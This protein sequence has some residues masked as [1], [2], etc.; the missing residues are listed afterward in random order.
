MYYWRLPLACN[1]IETTDG[2]TTEEKSNTRRKGG[3]GC[4]TII[5]FN[6]SK[7][8]GG[9]DSTGSDQRPPYVG[10]GHEMGHARAIDE[11]IQS[12]SN[13]EIALGI[14]K[15]EQQSMSV[16]NAIRLEHHLPLRPTY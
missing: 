16:E 3:L 5:R 7:T 8:S 13:I 12:Y 1:H 9:I 11:G 4:D 15:S 10:L 6:P 2:N 14:P